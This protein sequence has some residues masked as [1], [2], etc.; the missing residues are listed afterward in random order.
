MGERTAKISTAME[1]MLPQREV[2]WVA[3]MPAASVRLWK[4]MGMVVD[5]SI[6]NAEF[7]TSYRIQLFSLLV[8]FSAMERV[9]PVNLL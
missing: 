8:S 9:P 1:V 4:K 3:E 6:V 5:T 7:A 2:D